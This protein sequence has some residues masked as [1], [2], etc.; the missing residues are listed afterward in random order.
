MN[1]LQC[2]F[3][4]DR[5]LLHSTALCCCCCSSGLLFSVYRHGPDTAGILYKWGNARRWGIIYIYIET[6]TRVDHNNNGLVCVSHTSPSDRK[7][8]IARKSERLLGYPHGLSKY[9]VY[10]VSGANSVK[11]FV[12][13]LPVLRTR[14]VR[15]CVYTHIVAKTY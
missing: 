4:V 6:K 13:T 11:G 1:K 2:R 15:M 10:L 8:K 9:I 12:S 5:H 7:H 3:S 14:K